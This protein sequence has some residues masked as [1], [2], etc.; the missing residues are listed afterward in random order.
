MAR[1]PRSAIAAARN[2]DVTQKFTYPLDIEA[3]GTNDIISFGIMEAGV[4]GVGGGGISLGIEKS[5]VLPLPKPLVD[6]YPVQYDTN[7]N[8]SQLLRSIGDVAAT[9][10]GVTPGIPGPGTRV[11]DFFNS[12]G[13]RAIGAA[14]GVVANQFRMVTLAQ[15]E[16]RRHQLNW[17][18]APKSAAESTRLA[19]LIQS[20]RIG[21]TPDTFAGRAILLFPKI[22]LM[23]FIPNTQYMYRFKPCVLENLTVTY[24]GEQQT[25]AF[26]GALADGN[27]PPESLIVSTT[28]LELEYWVREDHTR[29]QGVGGPIGTSGLPSNSFDDAYNWYSIADGEGEFVA[30]TS[31]SALGTLLDRSATDALRSVLNFSNVVQGQ[32]TN[33]F[34]GNSGQGQ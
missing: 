34:G 27:H 18:F 13:A 5:Y 29:N 6:Q 23:F 30:P 26:Y 1:N 32:T 25:P 31:R 12:P 21:M 28:W 33:I 22:Y 11:T 9:P 10:S 24:D 8:F 14:A 16:F 17:K 20:L 4:T 15:P 3:G 19:E 7:Y 2:A